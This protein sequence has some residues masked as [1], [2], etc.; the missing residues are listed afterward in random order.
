MQDHDHP[1]PG[2]TRRD[3]LR[4]LGGVAALAFGGAAGIEV[5]DPTPQ[6]L[7]S[8]EHL[9]LGRLQHA[10]EAPQHSER[11]D[12]LAVPRLLVVPPQ[13]VGDRPDEGGVVLDLPWRDGHGTPSTSRSRSHRS[14]RRRLKATDDHPPPCHDAL[15]RRTSSTEKCSTLLAKFLVSRRNRD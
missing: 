15:R 13:Q 3:S 11:Q 9:G 1:A 2:L 10:V 6:L 5:L 12:D 14:S 4:K 7:V 8:V